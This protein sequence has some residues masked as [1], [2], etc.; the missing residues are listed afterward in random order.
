MKRFWFTFSLVSP[1]A[2]FVQPVLANTLPDAK[3]AI[4]RFYAGFY[5][6]EKSETNPYPGKQCLR[7]LTI[8]NG[9]IKVG[10]V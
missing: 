2:S 5:R 9:V 7:T 4:Y 3:G 8:N 6:Y 1:L 10:D